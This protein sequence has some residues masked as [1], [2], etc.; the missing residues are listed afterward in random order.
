[1][2]Y[3]KQ[4][5]IN[6]AYQWAMSRNPKYYD[7]EKLG[8][9]CTNYVSQCIFAGCG[10]MNYKKDLGWYYISANN[11]TPSWSGVE[12]LYKFLT[13][14]KGVGPYGIEIPLEE[15]EAGDIVQISFDGVKFTHSSFV[16]ATEPEIMVAQH[17]DN[18]I[19]RPLSTQ[20]YKKIRVIRIL[21]CR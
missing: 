7:F 9:D 6:Y 11:R 8:G 1:M 20:I 2:S 4:K 15:I 18:Y 3:F 12:Y 13:T 17:S 16:V 14:N 19:N 10:K 5:A 21:G